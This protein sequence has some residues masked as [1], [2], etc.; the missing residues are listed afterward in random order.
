MRISTKSNLE[1][2]YSLQQRNHQVVLRVHKCTEGEWDNIHQST[3]ST[4]VEWNNRTN[5]QHN[6]QRNTHS[7]I[8]NIIAFHDISLSKNA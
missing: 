4:N 2:N 5:S 3:T 1:H 6:Y 8:S 7:I